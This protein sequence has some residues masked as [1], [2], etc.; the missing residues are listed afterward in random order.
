MDNIH[1]L[2]VEFQNDADENVNESVNKIRCA[3][4]MEAKI[5]MAI[6]DSFVAEGF[7]KDEAFE[8]MLKQFFH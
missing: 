2:P 5:K 3:A 7:T 1:Q 8:I 6:V 4:R